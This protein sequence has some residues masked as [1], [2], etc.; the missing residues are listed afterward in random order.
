MEIQGKSYFRIFSIA[1]L[2]FFSFITYSF[3]A[4]TQDLI[5]INSFEN[6]IKPKKHANKDQ[7]KIY[8]ILER[9][10]YYNVPGVSLA[11]IDHGEIVFAKGY[12]LPNENLID[13][14]TLFQAASISKPLSAVMALSLVEKGKVSLDQ[15]INDVL[16]STWKVPDNRY[17]RREK[18]TLRRLLSHTAGLSVSG[19]GGYSSSLSQ[20]QLPTLIQTLKGLQPANNVAVVPVRVP[21]RSFAY[22]GG[23]YMVNE[24]MIQDITNADFRFLMD[25]T[26]FTPLNMP[27]STYALIWPGSGNMARGHMQD[28]SVVPGQWHLYPESAAAGLWTTPTELGRFMLDI[29]NTFSGKT[30]TILSTATVKKMLVRQPNSP[31]GLGLFIDQIQPTITEF[32]HTGYNRGFISA[33]VGFTSVDQGAI[34]MTNSENGGNLIPEIIDSIAA[35]YNWPS[36]YVE[37][38]NRLEQKFN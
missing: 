12:N 7:Q 38:Y 13:T 18:V 11:I 9:M 25:Q 34:I 2:F 4:T 24:K 8:N 1:L 17:T 26:I 3:S 28:G 31:V 10:Q 23:G 27:L 16:S 33:F 21:G 29:Q 20:S 35:S 32:S 14:N 37:P 15:N 5:K 30:N 22:S 19:F 6:N 36:G